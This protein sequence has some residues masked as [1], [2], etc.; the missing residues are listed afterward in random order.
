MVG[1]GE[2][3]FD[4]TIFMEMEKIVCLIAGGIFFFFTSK[5]LVIDNDNEVRAKEMCPTK[6]R[7][8]I[9]AS[10]WNHIINR[11]KSDCHSIE[12]H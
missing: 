3:K 6:W 8:I 4:S 12:M 10:Q 7:T 11:I 1:K 2:N 9:T 5:M